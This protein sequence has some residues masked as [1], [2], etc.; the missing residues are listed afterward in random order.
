VIP[1]RLL[2]RARQTYWTLVQRGLRTRRWWFVNRLRAVARLRHASIEIDV[3]PDVTLGRR[4]RVDIEPGS[5]NRVVLARGSRV[6]DD[7]VLW[8]RGGSIE[9]GAASALRRGC[10]LNTSGRLRIGSGVI[11]SWGVVIHCAESVEIDDMAIIGEYSTITD[12]M[13]QRTDE[14]PI[15]H[16]VRTR[17]TRIGRNV[18]IAAS[19]VVAQGVDVG[20]RAFVA[21]HSVVTKDVPPLWLAAGAPA[22]A[23]RQLEIEVEDA[24]T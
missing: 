8:L 24:A 15:L 13:H 14:A 2:P 1:E 3:A 5:K 4:V 7:V 23:I 21:A 16:H 18:W 9:L 11:V 6:Q 19:T 12:S 20:D 10:R 22:K 17:P